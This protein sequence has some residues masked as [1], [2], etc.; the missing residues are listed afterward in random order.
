M[1][2]VVE[3]VQHLR[4]HEELRPVE[5]LPGAAVVA[6]VVGG[7][8]LAGLVLPG[9]D[10]GALLRVVEG[11]VVHEV[12]V[13]AALVAVVPEDHRRVVDVADDQLAHE[14]AA[15]LGVVAVLPA[16]Q[17]VEDE[18]AELVARLEEVPVGRVVGH[19][20]GV[21]VHVL[22]ELH[23]HLAHR[24]AGG[25][26][27]VRPE[28]VA[29]DAL[30]PHLDAVDV[31]AV[32]GAQLDGAEAEALAGG[33]QR[34]PAAL[35]RDGDAVEVRRL[36]GPGAG[37]STRVSSVTCSAP[38]ATGAENGAPTGLPS[39]VSI[40]AVTTPGRRGAAGGRRCGRRRRAARRS[41]RARSTP[42]DGPRGTRAGRCRRR[43]RSRSGARP[44]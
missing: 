15:D 31:E 5:V 25:A 4:R 29:V 17:L 16:G 34:P 2:A 32:A 36:G 28:A 12:V 7:V 42:P 22:D 39:V 26:S 43:S 23:V 27:R 20:H 41:P 37:R 14:L 38:A 30:E 21:H 10:H 24:A 40:C 18:E 33:V 9:V 19:A 13:E 3:A 35:E 44:R 1:A 6:A 11:V 8:D